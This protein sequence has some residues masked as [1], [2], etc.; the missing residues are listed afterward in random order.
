MQ[1]RPR[2][3]AVAQSAEMGGAELALARILERLPTLG[4]DV[5]VAAPRASRRIHPPPSEDGRLP[6]QHRVAVGG[7]AAG[8][9]PRAVV[10]WPRARQLAAGFDLVLLN[11][12]VTQRLAPAMTRTTLVPY[13]HELVESK[14]R[15]WSSARFWRATPVV[16]CACETVAQRCRALGVP[17]E[18]LRVVYAPVETV[19]RAPRPEWAKGPTVGFVGRIEAHKGALDLALAMRGLDARLVVV[20]EGSGAYADQVRAAAPDALFVGRSQDARA[21][22]Q[23]FDVLAVPSHT[24]AFGTVAAEALAAG[25]P[26]VA[27]LGTGVAEYVVPGENGEL[28]M[29]GD[30]E[31]LAAAIRRLLP[32]AA[33]MGD[34]ARASVVRFSADAVAGNVAAALHEAMRMRAG[35]PAAMLREVRR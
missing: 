17:P 27:T 21:L 24:E 30:V 26:V 28:V 6:A 32:R 35:A 16:L 2:V 5:E 18:R 29:A 12:V 13:I 10:S 9:W 11:G 8:A 7:L 14:P 33:H 31:A 19:T 4:F 15:A 23:W 1:P 22:M 3:L 34:A 25:T 20:G